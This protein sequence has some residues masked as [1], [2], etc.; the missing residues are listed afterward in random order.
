[1][2]NKRLISLLC[3][4]MVC[5]LIFS[6]CGS[7]ENNPTDTKSDTT[8][9]GTENSD[10]TPEKPVNSTSD[11]T[12]TD[13][14]NSDI[15]TDANTSDTEADKTDNTLDQTQEAQN[16]SIF[17]SMS[18]TTD[19]LVKEAIE[20]YNAD[21]YTPL[22][23]P[24]KYNVLWLGYTHVTYEDL[25]FRMT[26]FDREYLKAVALNYEKCLE[27][28]TNN[29][30]DITVDL[31]FIDDA[32]PLTKTSGDEWLYLGQDTIQ[33]TVDKYCAEH[34]YDTVLTTIQTAGDENRER[35]EDKECYGTNYAILGVMLSNMNSSMG[36]S[37]FDLGVPVEGTYPLADPEVPSLY[38]TAVAVHEWMH[39]LEPLGNM[40][41]IEYPNTHA[42][43]GPESFPGY[44]KYINGANDYDYFEFY[45]LVLTGKLPYTSG[46]TVKLVGMYPKMWPLI[47]RNTRILGSFTIKAADGEGYLTGRSEDPT[48]ILSDNP[49]V[50]NIKYLSNG[51]FM[52]SPADLPDKYIDLGNAW[53]MEGNTIGLWVYTGYLD[54]QSWRVIDNPDGTY[55][56]QTPY[57]SGRL[58]TTVNSQGSFLYSAGAGS[59]QKW[60]IEPVNK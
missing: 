33:P 22:S 53:D 36:Y 39:Q 59:A 3:I 6:A 57:E 60:I 27:S 58:M 49:A 10:K 30:L 45:K 40:L 1:M 8:V 51:R 56:I 52:F 9:T 12:K 4:L 17:A 35:N 19:R 46:D 13:E 23:E 43:F 31:Y 38:A 50:W 18:E 42:Y 20:Q 14:N 54:A 32:T 41:G 11:D 24:V 2:K 21:D 7:K 29:I 48:L 25:D 15:K 37:T 34:E 55:S 5:T 47:K 28:I 26:D 44:Q 16:I